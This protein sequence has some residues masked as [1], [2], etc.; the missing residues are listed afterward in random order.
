MM[1]FAEGKGPRNGLD[2][3]SNA[4]GKKQT[5]AKKSPATT[6]ADEKSDVPAIRPGEKL[7]DYSRRVDAALPLSGLVNKSVRNGVDPLG[8]KVRRTR[9]EKK[10][11]KLYDEWREEDR[12]IKEQ[13]EEELE[14]AEEREME[15]D[16]MGV[17]WKMAFQEENTGGKKKK[18]GKRGRYVGEAGDREEDPWEEIKR[19]RGEAKIGL[20]D[21]A[22]APPEFSKLPRKKITVGGAVVDV[23]SVPKAAGSLRRREELQVVREQVVATYRKK[24]EAKRASLLHEA[25]T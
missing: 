3:G 5:T 9:K 20:N 22:L 1:A 14:L 17:S 19:K 15:N 16:S 6:E 10:M 4:R 2:D 18:K 21:V 24:S 7:S 23:G 25:S 13:R 12:K 8:L 11:H